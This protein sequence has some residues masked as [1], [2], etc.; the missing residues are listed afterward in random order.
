MSRSWKLPRP[1]LVD[2]RNAGIL[3]GVTLMDSQSPTRIRRRDVLVFGGVAMTSAAIPPA[4]LAGQAV[5]VRPAPLFVADAGVNEP[6][7][8]QPDLAMLTRAQHEWAL[9][10]LPHLY[11]QALDRRDVEALGRLFTADAEIVV[12]KGDR[13]DRARILNIPNVHRAGYRATFHSVFNQTLVLGDKTATGEVY[14]LARHLFPERNGKH[15]SNDMTLRYEDQ[16]RLEDDNCWRFS[17]RRIVMA[18]HEPLVEIAPPPGL[19]T[20]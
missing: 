11:A 3:E 15:F 17:M 13:W 2:R 10:K 8:R 7:P 4:T 1:P 18:A 6:V 14:C 16:Y 9:N 20:P 19:P 5:P 12:G